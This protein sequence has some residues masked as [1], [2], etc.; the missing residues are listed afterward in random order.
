MNLPESKGEAEMLIAQIGDLQRQIQTIETRM[1][2]RVAK[3]KAASD[4]KAAPLNAELKKTF[5][6][7]QA[8]AEANRAELTESG[9]RK[10]VEMGAGTIAW[11]FDPLSITVSTKKLEGILK[12]LRSKGLRRLIRSTHNVDKEAVKD[13]LETNP[14]LIDG[15]DG[16]GKKRTETFSVKP[17]VLELEVTA[18]KVASESE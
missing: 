2:D 17:L 7:V 18:T 8:W 14:K 1:Q 11:R 15:I 3:L 16:L 4:Q 10:T 9:K 5:E 12:T 6:R 13:G